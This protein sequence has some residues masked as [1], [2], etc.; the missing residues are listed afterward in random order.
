MVR[1]ARLFKENVDNMVN[2][3]KICVIGLGYVG[4]PLAIEFSKYFKVIGYDLSE[5][6]I[7]TLNQ[8]IDPNGEVD[9][10]TLKNSSAVWSS[11]PEVMDE[12]DV[13][14]IT[15][16]TPVD[17]NNQPDLSCLESASELVGRAL[18]PGGLVVYE[19]T[20]F[21][22]C[23]E[24]FCR[25]IL[26]KS[27]GL[28]H[29]KHFYLGY[30]PERVNPSDKVNTVSKITKV[31]SGCCD[32]STDLVDSLYQKIIE[33]GTFRASSI[34]VAEA[35]KVTENIQRDVNIALMN[36]LSIVFDQL[37]IDSFEVIHAASS[38]WNF[39]PFRPGLVGG[40]CIGVD[41]YYLIARAAELN[42]NTPLMNS[43]RM[44]NEAVVERVVAKVKSLF[45]GRP[46]V[47]LM[48]LTFK[49]D[50]PDLR[51]SKSIVLA[52]KLSECADVQAIDPYVKRQTSGTYSTVDDFS[53]GPFDCIIISVRHKNFIDIQPE[54][55]RELLTPEGKVFD[56]LNAF[57][58]IKD[59]SL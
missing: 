7:H 57:P 18:K 11:N 27:S 58:S 20:V 14:I 26:E 9:S 33:A 44:I 37:D 15:V 24:D 45:S 6:R 25:P 59:Y 1:A 46:R 53:G 4:L 3:Q 50:C 22:G 47:L 10:K 13:F 29:G 17:K 52:N 49:E 30:S 32:E 48:G 28:I 12:S 16:P 40:H 34:K 39:I 23:T 43:A 2:T 41:P 21:P 35:A 5:E 8:C 38:K 36:E 54:F 31:V 42:V 56:L 51:N 55:I 19:S